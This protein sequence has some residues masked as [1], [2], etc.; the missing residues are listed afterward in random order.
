M[1]RGRTIVGVLVWVAAAVLTSACGGGS[2]EPP[3][4]TASP[5]TATPTASPTASPTPPPTATASIEEE[6]AEAYL[7][8]WEAYAEAVLNLDLSLVEDFVSGEE[9]DGI[10]EEIATYE[11]NGVAARISVEHDFTVVSADEMSAVVIDQYVNNS[12]FVDAETK[13]PE[14]G[15]GTGEVFRDTVF[16][17]RIDGRWVVVR[18]TREQ[19]D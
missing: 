15:E 4:A 11:A 9:L 10:R 14:E 3:T 5:A 1:C 17:E 12:F 18:G 2:S 8:Y 19:V 13:E 7:A 16:M 6:V